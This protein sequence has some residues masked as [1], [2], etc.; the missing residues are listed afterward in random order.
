M[1]DD[2]YADIE[3]ECDQIAVSQ[4]KEQ[5]Q[6]SETERDRLGLDAKAANEKVRRPCPRI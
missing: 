4:L 5:L 6:K 1:E 2:L 3:K